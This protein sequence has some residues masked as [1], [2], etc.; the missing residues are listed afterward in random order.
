VE[1]KP[2]IKGLLIII[3]MVFY[4]ILP[5]HAMGEDNISLRGISL[6]EP[7]MAEIRGGFETPNGNF[8][9]F[10]MDFMQVRFLSHN[11]LNIQNPVGW[12]NALSK[13]AVITKDGMEFEMQIFQAGGGNPENNSTSNS[14]PS[15]SSTAS[16]NLGSVSIVDSFVNN[17]GFINANLITG[18]FNTASIANLINI[19]IVFVN[20]TA[21]LSQFLPVLRMPPY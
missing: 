15:N 17:Q 14:S 6:T 8:F 2:N 12:V 3:V 1:P 10:S 7:E 21:N 20:N 4:L 11:E 18:N 9:Y 13:R 16:N 5:H 19:H